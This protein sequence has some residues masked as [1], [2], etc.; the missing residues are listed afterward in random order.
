MSVDVLGGKKTTEEVRQTE[1]K[2][3]SSIEVNV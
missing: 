3:L 2:K 1:T